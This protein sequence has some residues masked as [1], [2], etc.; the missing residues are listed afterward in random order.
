MSNAQKTREANINYCSKI[1]SKDEVAIAKYECSFITKTNKERH[2][3]E[4]TDWHLVKDLAY[5]KQDIS[6]IDEA[7]PEYAIKYRF[8]IKDM[9]ETA[10]AKQVR[11]DFEEQYESAE[12]RPWQS[13]LVDELKYPPND[14]K[15]IWIWENQGN[16]GKSWLSCYLVA[17]HG[18]IRFENAATKDIAHAYNGEGIVV[19]DFSR[20]TEE[21]LNYQILESIKNKVL[22]SPKYNSC[23]KYFKSPHVI[24][25]A[26]WPPNRATMSQDRWDVRHMKDTIVGLT[27]SEP[28]KTIDEL[29]SCNTELVPNSKG[30]GQI[31][32][33]LED[34]IIMYSE[35]LSTLQDEEPQNSVKIDEIESK[36][37]CLVFQLEALEIKL[38]IRNT[39]SED[40]IM[41]DEPMILEI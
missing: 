41:N 26:N 36:L 15:I 4:R 19:F 22:F 11:A 12:L 2:Q 20:T 31:I 16:I 25:L 7:F 30:D 24:C 38:A 28:C 33:Q 18:A 5:E 39:E 27:N 29:P 23:S 32:E 14:R 6:E 21:R 37:E 1:E 3:G 35:Q 9:I 40:N 8:A 13:K 34:E 17:K 10:K